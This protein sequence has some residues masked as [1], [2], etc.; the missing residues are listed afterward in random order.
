M[1]RQLLVFKCFLTKD[2]ESADGKLETTDSHLHNAAMRRYRI[3]FQ[4]AHD[5]LRDNSQRQGFS[6]GLVSLVWRD[7]VLSGA[8]VRI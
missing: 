6:H 8:H 4:S 1:L 3:G 5:G 2:P 7:T